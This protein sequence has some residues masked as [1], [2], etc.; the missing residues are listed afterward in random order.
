MSIH[1]QIEGIL[2][3]IE[4]D[5]ST[6]LWGE[7]I[8]LANL[9]FNEFEVLP[10]SKVAAVDGSSVMVEPYGGLKIGM[11]RAGFVLY[12]GRRLKKD[13]SGI[14]V[15]RLDFRNSREIY[16]KRY[17][18]ILDDEPPELAD[19]DPSYMMQRLRTLE[20]FRYMFRALNELSEGDILLI[21]GALRGDRHTPDRG[22]ALLSEMAQDRGVSLVGISKDSGLM[23]GALPL[24]PQVDR[25]A[26][27]R[28]GHRR[29]YTR[30]LG[31]T[32]PGRE[33]LFIARFNPYGEHAFRTDI[34]SLESVPSVLGKVAWYC[35]DPAYVGYPY[36]LA[37]AHNEVIIRKGT[38]EDIGYM[39]EA[40]LPENFHRKLDRGV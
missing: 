22:I 34:I 39:I 33:T 19:T 16:E 27:E 31:R 15:M 17:K 8:D 36:P 29:W 13:I 38:A 1:E 10:G 4:Q 14:E 24:V 32:S 5:D 25:V 9:D 2:R 40:N 21:D 11:I 3:E 26:E 23:H 7:E 28:I 30:V 6:Q 35:S 37:D 20:E 18:E 12:H